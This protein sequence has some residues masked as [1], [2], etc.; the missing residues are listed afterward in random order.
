MNHQAA[1]SIVSV[2][3]RGEQIRDSARVAATRVFINARFLTQ[4]VTGVQRYGRELVRALDGLLERGFAGAARYTF[5][6]LAPR[7][8]R[9][10]HDGLRLRHLELRWVGRLRGHLWEQLE[11]PLYA[12]G[13]L[14]VSPGQAGPL[15]KRKQI[16]T[17]HDAAVFAVAGGFSAPFRIWYRILGIGLGRVARRVVTDSKFSAQELHRYCR[18]DER[19]LRVIPLGVEHIRSVVPD[20][21]VLDR[22][23]LGRRPF[24]LGVSS[25]N[26]NKNLHGIAAAVRLLGERDYDVVIAGGANPRVFAEM[27][28]GVPANVRYL[29]YVTDSELRALYDRASCFVYPSFYEGF[30]LPP[31][32]AMACGCPVIVSNTASLPEVCGRA[33]LYCNPATPADIANKIDAVMRNPVLQSEMRRRG[34]EQVREFTWERCAR[35]MLAL[36]D[37]TLAASGRPA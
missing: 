26:P 33:A 9:A 20:Y 32:E 14:L 6:L 17:I 8:S 10:D 1:D 37:E 2:P 36:V 23:E 15:L 30:G 16:V 11:L 22:H 34:L 21:S 25:L 24:V 31:L 28:G 19:K 3:V 12:R 18:I 4:P 5:V 27:D 35:M 7:A 29:G 13:C